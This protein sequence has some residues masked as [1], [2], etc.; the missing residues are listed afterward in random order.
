MKRC[1]MCQKEATKENS[2]ININS[3]DSKS[4]IWLCESCISQLNGF[5]EKSKTMAEIE[6]YFN[7]EEDENNERVEDVFKAIQST[8]IKPRDIK[9]YLDKHVIGQEEAKKSLSIAVYNHS[10]RIMNKDAKIGKSNVLIYGPSGTGKTELARSLAEIVDVPFVVADA[11][12]LTEA[13]YVGDDVENILLMLLQKANNDIRRAENG[14]IYIDE[15]DKIARKSKNVSITRDVSGEGVQQALLKLIEGNMVRVHMAGGRKH[16]QGEC[17]EFDTSNLLFICAGAF[18]GLVTESEKKKHFG[19]SSVV[20]DEEEKQMITHETFVKFGMTPEFMGRLPVITYTE[21]LD[22]SHMRR[23]M[24]EPENSIINQYINLLA[25][26]GIH[27][28]LE[29]SFFDKVINEVMSSGIG[30]RGIR[31]TIESLMKDVMFDAP[32]YE[33]GTTVV[34]TDKG[35]VVDS[36]IA[37]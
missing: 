18:E 3:N 29:D 30:A 31:T 32:S 10:K 16:P 28:E 8:R 6:R 4:N 11:T 35:G 7:G 1:Y 20:E 2:M 37:V 13:G 12:T 22:R 14:I 5:S 27:L 33:F 21:T 24:T 17:V 15:I 26:D 23:I 9:A 36:K 25:L 19:F 34:M